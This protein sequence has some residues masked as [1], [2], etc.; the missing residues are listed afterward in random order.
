MTAPDQ[1]GVAQ[2][3][4]GH[5]SGRTTHAHYNQARAIDAS[6]LYA[7]VLAAAAGPPDAPGR[8]GAPHSKAADPCAR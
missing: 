6:R 2:D 1:I 3:L 5:A 8:S 7:T 4:L